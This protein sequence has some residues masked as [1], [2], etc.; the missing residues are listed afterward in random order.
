MWQIRRHLGILLAATLT[1]CPLNVHAE[2]ARPGGARTDTGPE[3]RDEPVRIQVNVNMFFPGPAGESE[4]S[5]KLRERARRSSYEL[6][7]GECALVEQ[8][9]AKTCRL[10]SVSVNISRQTNGQAE[11]YMAGANFV[12]RVTLK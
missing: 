6:A 5:V 12:L 3:R 10:E 1:L 11:G 9:L 7:A 4:E 2:D 8:V